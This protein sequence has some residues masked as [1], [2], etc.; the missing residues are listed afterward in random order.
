VEPLTEDQL[1]T[2]FETAKDDRLYAAYV[3]AATTGLRR[4]ELLGLCWDCVDLKGGVITV[5]RQLLA[6]EDGP[7]WTT[8]PRVNEA[9]G[10]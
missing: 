10:A 1:L 9:G 5:Q 4:G 6:L 2:F 7:L 8:A 3:L